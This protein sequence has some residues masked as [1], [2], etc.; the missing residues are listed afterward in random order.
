MHVF[1]SGTG[2]RTHSI[3]QTV[4][5]INSW[6]YTEQFIRRMPLFVRHRPVHCFFLRDRSS[7]AVDWLKN[8]KRY[9]LFRLYRAF[10]MDIL[11]QSMLTIN[12]RITVGEIFCIR[13]H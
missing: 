4:G 10:K 5:C 8:G 3:A 9:I 6:W 2:C 7:S 13:S 1:V 12:L 11:V